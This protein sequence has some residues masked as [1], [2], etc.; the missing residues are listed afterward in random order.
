MTVAPGAAV[1][2]DRD[3]VLIRDVHHLC[4][5]EQIEVLV[6]VAEALRILR[7]EGFKLV[8]VTNQ[9]VVARGKLTEAGLREIHRMLS[10]T[11]GAEGAQLDAIYYCPHHPTDGIGAYKIAC[12]CRKPNTGMIE[13]AA[14]ELRLEP[15]HSYLVGDQAGD[16]ELAARVG[17][18]G[19]LIRQAT[20][21]GGEVLAG[22]AHAFD[23]LLQ[24]ARWIVSQTGQPFR[25]K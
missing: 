16:M 25:S 9:S 3:G 10:A 4:R 7:S 8:V 12:A 11:L 23:N 15:A 17:A 18:Q 1:F 21:A 14:R 13:R 20:T 19:M 22:T 24:A 5:A 6:G 2:L